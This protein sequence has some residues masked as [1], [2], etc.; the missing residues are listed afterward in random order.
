MQ[1]FHLL[2]ELCLNSKYPLCLEGKVQTKWNSLILSMRV[3]SVPPPGGREIITKQ[4]LCCPPSLKIEGAYGWRGCVWVG[5]D[6]ESCDFSSC[7]NH[8]MHMRLIFSVSYEIPVDRWLSTCILKCFIPRQCEQHPRRV[9][10][11]PPFVST[12]ACSTRFAKVSF[13]ER[14]GRPGHAVRHATVKAT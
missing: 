10:P 4:L 7:L 1:N 9:M 11:G 13:D 12:F 5:F 3:H 2:I 8:V 6:K 14:G